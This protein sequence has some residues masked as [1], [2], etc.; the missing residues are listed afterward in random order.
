MDYLYLGFGSCVHEFAKIVNPQLLFLDDF[1]IIGD[2]VFALATGHIHIGKFVNISPHTTITG[3][4]S[5]T[6]GDFTEVSSGCRIITGTDDI[7]GDSL[8][9][10]NVPKQFR[11][12]TRSAVEI[13]DFCAIGSNSIIF[14]GVKIGQGVIV[15]PGTIVKTNLKPWHI[16]GGSEC[17]NLGIRKYKNEILSKGRDSINGISTIIAEMK[18]IKKN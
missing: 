14:P 9:T 3:G 10:P 18:L 16:Y 4:G 8:F 11:N 17:K 7:Y 12:I 6:I 1:S 2:F 13:A 15:T 5:L